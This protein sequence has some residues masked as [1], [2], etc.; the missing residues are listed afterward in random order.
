MS[1]TISGMR[2]AVATGV[3][4]TG[5]FP[6]HNMTISLLDQITLPELSPKVQ[7]NDLDEII[8]SSTEA[9]ATLLVQ[10]IDGKIT[11]R[12][13][14]FY[15][16]GF[17]FAFRE[18]AQLTETLQAPVLSFFGDTIKVYNFRGDAVDYA[19]QDVNAPGKY[20]YGSS[21]IKMYNEV[22]RGTHLVK[23]GSLAIMKIANH[24]VFGY[25]I[26]F[27]IQQDGNRD[28]MSSFAMS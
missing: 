7:P 6:S 26:N 4:I 8:N 3:S 24:L 25:P 12:T 2:A 1:A 10:N 13:N 15:L 18:K 27:Q 19:S 20:Y 16:T 21:L 23:T 17:S 14:K 9:G 11:H 5:D 28:K 22:L